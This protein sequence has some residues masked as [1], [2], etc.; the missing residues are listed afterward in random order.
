MKRGFNQ[1]SEPHS[2]EDFGFIKVLKTDE[3]QKQ[4]ANYAWLK[5]MQEVMIGE[6]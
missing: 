6:R 3:Y 1:I 5:E 2:L 4:L